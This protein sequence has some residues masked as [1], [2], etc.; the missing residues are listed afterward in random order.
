MHISS[1]SDVNIYGQELRGKGVF[2]YSEKAYQFSYPCILKYYS[3]DSSVTPKL[4]DI[5]KVTGILSYELP[6]NEDLDS[7][8]EENFE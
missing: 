1:G 6:S 8:S 7:N 5:V 2:N 4:N 3:I